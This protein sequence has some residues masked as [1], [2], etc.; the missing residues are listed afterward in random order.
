MEKKVTEDNEIAW[1]QSQ[2]VVLDLK[3]QNAEQELLATAAALCLFF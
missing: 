2:A 1:I 3:V